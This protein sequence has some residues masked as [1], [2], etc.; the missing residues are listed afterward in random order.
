MEVSP[1]KA[2]FTAS[3]STYLE[4]AHVLACSSLEVPYGH[5]VY[6]KR[7]AE[8]RRLFGVEGVG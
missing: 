6:K 1:Q 7:A 2:L 3:L 5:G 4:N 8:T